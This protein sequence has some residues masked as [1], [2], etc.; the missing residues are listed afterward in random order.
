[1]NNP[2]YQVVYGVGILDD[3][4]N[5]FPAL[6]YE[7]GRFQNLSHVFSYVRNQLNTRFNLFAY[8]AGLAR[9]SSAAAQQQETHWPASFASDIPATPPASRVPRQMPRNLFTP[10]RGAGGGAGAEEDEIM[11]SI[12]SASVLLNMLNLGLGDPIAT[13]GLPPAPIAGGTPRTAGIWAAFRAP[14]VVAPSITVLNTN[15]TILNGGEI[16]QADATCTICQDTIIH[17]D[18]CR[19]LTACGHVYHKV[20]IDQWFNRS[21]F[22]PSCRHDVR[23]PRIPSP[24]LEAAS[25]PSASSPSAGEGEGEGAGTISTMPDMA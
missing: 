22:C 12:T 23:E 10:M 24:R 6:L 3:V 5:Y 15:T 14:V 4:H 20:C 8:G 13:G 17:S 7:Q 25:A 16:P 11:A 21:V 19:R 1:M 9:A 18:I 2:D